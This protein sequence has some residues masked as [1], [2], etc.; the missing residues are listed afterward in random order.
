MVSDQEFSF[1]ASSTYP[2]RQIIFRKFYAEL[3]RQD[4]SSNGNDI[5][6]PKSKQSLHPF[7]V[8][9]VL[10]WMILSKI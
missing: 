4:N 2:D 5:H 8:W 3:T 10:L 7:F 6:N 1:A 9:M